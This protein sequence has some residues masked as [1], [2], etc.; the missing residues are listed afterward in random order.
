MQSNYV[1]NKISSC[2]SINEG[3]EHLLLGSRLRERLHGVV[4][5][6]YAN[7]MVTTKGAFAYSQFIVISVVTSLG[8]RPTA[9]PDLAKIFQD[10][11]P[12]EENRGSLI[13]FS[14]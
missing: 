2:I 6:V 5:V 13:F 9:D 12:A 11:D 14:L 8:K 7:T 1:G 3:N 4:R 10:P